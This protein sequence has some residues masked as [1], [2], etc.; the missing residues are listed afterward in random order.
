MKKIKIHDIIEMFKVID[1]WGIEN[2]DYEL[3]KNQYENNYTDLV[4]NLT[5]LFK[6]LAYHVLD[7]A[8]SEIDYEDHIIPRFVESEKEKTNITFANYF[9]VYNNIL[10]K[11]DIFLQPY[12]VYT[13]EEP[14]IIK[15]KVISEL[16]NMI[17]DAENKI[18]YTVIHPYP[19]APE[20]EE[21]LKKFELDPLLDVVIVE[22]YISAASNG[23]YDTFE[24]NL[25]IRKDQS[26][27][28]KY[29]YTNAYPMATYINSSNS[30][31]EFMRE[32]QPTEW[33]EGFKF[34]GHYGIS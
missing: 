20:E 22:D 21:I 3:V 27:V 10:D 26:T 13:D 5:E 25:Y 24:G 11:A 33:F 19:F 14:E 34:M 2:I 31:K 32:V 4:E 23:G 29:D 17:L 8:L 1:V 30:M 12:M 7:M 6:E 28:E 15:E 16:K 9:V 18:K